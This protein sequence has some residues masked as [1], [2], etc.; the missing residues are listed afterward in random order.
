MRRDHTGPADDREEVRATKAD[1]A[2]LSDVAQKGWP[3]YD[4]SRSTVGPFQRSSNGERSVTTG[5]ET[6]NSTGHPSSSGLS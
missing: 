2:A 1:D 3:S 5:W 6:W 4:P